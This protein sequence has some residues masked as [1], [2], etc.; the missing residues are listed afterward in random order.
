MRLRRLSDSGLERMGTFLDSLMSDVPE[1]YPGSI[2]TDS[3]MSDDLPVE[4]DIDRDQRFQRRFESAAYLYERL[5]EL[6]APA[7]QQ[8]ERDRGLW[9]WLALLWFKQLC[10][11]DQSGRLKSGE[12]A[13]W[14]P[15]LN[16]ARRYYRHLLLG[17]YLIYR[18][19]ATT[20]ERVEAVLSNAIHVGTGEVFRTIVETQ[21]FVTSAA[22]VTLI[23]HLYYD[24]RTRRLIRGAGTKGPGGVRRLGDLLSQLDL[25]FDLHS[26]RVDDL[27]SLLPDEFLAVRR[28][29]RVP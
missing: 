19:H 4:I 13:R 7:D 5:T 15:V 10:P 9:A 17:P 24:P 1:N 14:I 25:T 28:R 18:A 23:D 2:L 6:R 12:R 8:L 29:A 16:D 11:P 20:P 22:V 26:I 27:V 3:A 21:Q